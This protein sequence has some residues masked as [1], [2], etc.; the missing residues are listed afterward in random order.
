MVELDDLIERVEKATGADRALDGAIY[1]HLLEENRTERELWWVE[2]QFQTGA[3]NGDWR[4]PYTASLDAA[5]ALVERKLPG[6]VWGISRFR[7]AHGAI[8][9]HVELFN[10]DGDA[11]HAADDHF[12]AEGITP[13]LAVILALLRALK[14][15]EGKETP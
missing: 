15:S 12:R 4:A 14:S 5:L 11:P 2:L 6:C 9:Y 8:V 1:W 10:I 13:A 7:R 3:V